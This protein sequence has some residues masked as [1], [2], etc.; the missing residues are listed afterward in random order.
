[1]ATQKNYRQMLG[2][3]LQSPAGNSHRVIEWHAKI[4]CIHLVGKSYLI[5]NFRLVK[6]LSNSIE[7][8]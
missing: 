5:Q 4:S 2:K 6:I 7:Q 1:M 3:G 8:K